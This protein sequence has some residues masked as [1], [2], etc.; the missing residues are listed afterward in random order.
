MEDG[1]EPSDRKVD[2]RFRNHLIG[3]V[4][5]SIASIAFLSLLGASPVLILEVFGLAAILGISAVSIILIYGGRFQ[6]RWKR[7]R[8]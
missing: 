7:R 2:R 8:P 5:V 6:I 1:G 4:I 3:F